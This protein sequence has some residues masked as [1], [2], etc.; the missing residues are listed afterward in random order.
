M[1]NERPDMT[2]NGTGTILAGT[3]GTLTVRGSGH[4]CGPVDCIN[5]L[6]SGSIRSDA[7]V[8]CQQELNCAGSAHFDQNL[9]ASLV[10]CAG[11]LK[12]DGHLHGGDIHSKGSIQVNGDFQGQRLIGAGSLRINGN[13]SAT[14]FRSAGSANVGGN[15]RAQHIKFSASAKVKG[16]VEAE[17]LEAEASIHID[18]LLSADQIVLKLATPGDSQIGNIGGSHIQV[19][20]QNYWG[21]GS[22]FK[23]GSLYVTAIEGDMISL[24]NTYANVVRGEHITIGEGCHIDRVEYSQSITISPAAEVKEQIHIK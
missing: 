2:Y 15:I 19:I 16:Q 23:I 12:V 6:C 4:I 3:Y 21:L 7:S 9:T 11:S 17:A 24:E 5:L 20:R 14:E 1:N 8:H 18:G 22:L 13:I 10:H